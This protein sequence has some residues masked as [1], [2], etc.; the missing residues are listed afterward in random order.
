MAVIK[1]GSCNH[2]YN[3]GQYES[4]PSCG[5]STADSESS[6]TDFIEETSEVTGSTVD[7][8]K[9]ASSSSPEQSSLGNDL[10]DESTVALGD[11]DDDPDDQV[12]I[13]MVK[14]DSGIDPVCGW[15][16]CIEGPDKGRDFRI[17]TER[18]FIGRGASMDIVIAGDDSISREN[19]G[20]ITFDPRTLKFTISTGEGRGLLYLNQKV[21]ESAKALKSYDLVE[22]GE[23]K[24]LFLPFC[25]EKFSWDSSSDKKE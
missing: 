14:K 19:H 3:D 22:V 16:V 17:K 24:L 5:V 13:P 2:F 23:T 20:S 25:T 12:T 11:L 8:S 4:C 10:D 21:V 18:N 7:L 9:Y 1:C 6:D 15:L